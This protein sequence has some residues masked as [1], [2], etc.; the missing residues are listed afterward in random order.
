M[1]PLAVPCLSRQ[2]TRVNGSLYVDDYHTYAYKNGQYATT[3]LSFHNFKLENNVLHK[4]VDFNTKEWIERVI[5]AGVNSN[6]KSIHLIK[7]D[8]SKV[9]LGHTYDASN[10]V[11]TIRKPGVNVAEKWIIN[12]H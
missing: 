1:F 12:L 3:D 7:A 8:G 11:L 10:K 6:P 5:V 9:E 4:G 2:T